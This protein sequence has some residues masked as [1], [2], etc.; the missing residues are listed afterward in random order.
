MCVFLERTRSPFLGEAACLVL[1]ELY[2][3]LSIRTQIERR[4]RLGIKLVG[5]IKTVGFKMA[6]R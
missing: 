3:L 5:V 6:I 4:V 1:K 2:G